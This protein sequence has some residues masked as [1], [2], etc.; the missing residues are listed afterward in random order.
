MNKIVIRSTECQQYIGSEVV[1]QGRIQAVRQ[2]GGVTFVVLRDG[3]GTAQAVYEQE[4]EK[5]PPLEAVVRLGG[6]VTA[7]PQAPNGVELHKPEIEL[8]VEP[9]APLPVAMHKRRL[10]AALPTLLDNGV[11]LNR[12]PQRRA[13]FR[14]SAG[15]MAAFRSYLNSQ[16]F[17]EIQSPKLVA[18]ATEGGANV[19]ELGYFGRPAYLAQSPQFYKQIMVGVFDRVYEVGPVFRAEPH[20]TSRHINQYVSLDV[21]F[22]FIENHFTVMGLVEQ[23]LRSIFTELAERFPTELALLEVT[24]PQA[25]ESFPHIH[26]AEALALITAETGRNV[27]RRAGPRT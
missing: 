23:L 6:T 3:W 7:M 25:P 5:M 11:V 12:H 21:E 4:P 19:F 10:K 9:A 1:L 8:L 16:H 18:S 17:T 22:G 27:L 15:V 24:L 26:F 13:V 20:N 2:M 14:L